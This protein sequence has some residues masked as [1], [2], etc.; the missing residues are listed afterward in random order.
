MQ[1]EQIELKELIGQLGDLKKEIGE[2]QERIER[3][4]EELSA[5]KRGYTESDIVSLGKRGK[6][7]L[8]SRKITGFPDER[9]ENRKRLL[10]R[11]LRQQEDRQQD[12][13][14]LVTAIEEKISTVEHSGLRRIL[15]LKYIEGLSWVQVAHRTGKSADACRMACE[16]FL[17]KQKGV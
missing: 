2:K 15:E 5:M 6:K 14:E 7:S 4:K 11:R 8:G 17:E 1:H 13:L 10:D 9:Y 12:L 16:R 3:L